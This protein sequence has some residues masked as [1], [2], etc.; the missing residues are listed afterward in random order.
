ML[1]ENDSKC[2]EDIKIGD[3]VYSKNVETGEVGYKEVKNTFV[4]EVDTLVKLSIE[5]NKII[6]TLNHPFWVVDNGWVEAGNLKARDKVLLASGKISRVCSIDI[7]KLKEKIKVYNFKVEDWHTYY[8]SK[9]GILVH[10]QCF[11]TEG[12]VDAVEWTNYGYK[13]FPQKNM[14]WKDCE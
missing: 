3:K 7:E 10:N 6:T 5:D 11:V 1:T 2:I 9:D 14:S 12:A 4:K 13:H 8:V